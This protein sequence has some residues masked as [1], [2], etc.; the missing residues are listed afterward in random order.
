M[1]NSL[2]QILAILVAVVLAGWMVFEM[3]F[4]A[5]RALGEDEPQVDLDA[6]ELLPELDQTPPQERHHKRIR[7]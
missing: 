6:P 4:R 1:S 7:R 3:A 5:G 2:W